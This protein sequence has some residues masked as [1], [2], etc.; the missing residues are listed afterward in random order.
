MI[1]RK[2]IAAAL[3]EIGLLLELKGEGGFKA[4]AYEAAARAIER[5]DDIKATI[6]RKSLLSVPGIGKSTAA[7]IESLARSGSS[8]LLEELRSAF[9]EGLRDLLLLPG[10][11]V[12]KAR[13]LWQQL[14]ITSINELEDAC[15]ENR[16]REV[17]G[18]GPKSQ[19][20]YLHAITVHRGRLGRFLIRDAWEAAQEIIESRKWPR[21]EIA[22]ELRRQLE[23]LREVVF[24][25]EGP[26]GETKEAAK[27]G[28]PLR[29]LF[30]PAEIFDA[31]W[32]W[33]SA[34]EEHRTTLA[35][36]AVERGMT[37]D[38]GG[39]RRGGTVLRLDEAAIY[40]AVG[41]DPF[42]PLLREGP[43]G[44][45][46]YS[47]PLIGPESIHGVFH[48]HTTESD[49]A[50]TVEEMVREAE[51]L[52]YKWIGVSDHSRSAFYAN[53]LSTERLLS[54][55][56]AI[57]TIERHHPGIRV[58]HGIES[59]IL[60][61]GSLDYPDS[62]LESLD[63]VIVSIHSAMRMPAETMTARIERALR[64]PATTHWGHPSGRL[65]LAREPY[66]CDFER[67][68]EVSAECGVSIE[69]NASHHRLDLDWRRIPTARAL[70]VPISVNPDAHSAEGL[71][72]ARVSVG[73]A[74]K[75]GLTPSDVLNSMGAEEIEKWLVKRRRR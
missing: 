47:G 9:P 51:R 73:T 11:G 3:E 66:E 54:Q 69:F 7:Q 43:A 1:D 12:K 35:A 5:I 33:E 2:E 71:A 58:F 15:V 26:F 19:A 53:G 75:G 21:I 74:A 39:L 61:D 67:L 48:V 4:R 20:N 10:L 52:G 29:I 37:L 60:P 13:A 18:F 42:H 68:I 56:E 27:I 41:L 59:D 49:G 65:L 46:G 45:N 14:G 36:R 40:R 32:L 16:L 31:C 55:A 57:R 23:I 72:D 44:E 70:G 22:G 63:F 50:A 30:R 34:S 62:I 38:A 6:E 24:I 28:I 25:V 64:H 17:A 8:P